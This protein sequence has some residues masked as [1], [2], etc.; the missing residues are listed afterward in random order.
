MNVIE[1]L[2]LMLILLLIKGFFSGSE[3]ALVSSD[4]I[5]MRHKARNPFLPFLQLNA[6]VR[7]R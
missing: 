1:T 2:V 3:I 7:A 6:F 4:K 5:K